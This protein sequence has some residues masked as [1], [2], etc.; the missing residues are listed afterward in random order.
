MQTTRIRPG[1]EADNSHPGR[2]TD[3][4][5]QYAAGH[6]TMAVMAGR[7]IALQV[8]RGGKGLFARISLGRH[9]PENG[10]HGGAGMLM[11]QTSL[12]LQPGSHFAPLPGQLI[13][14]CNRWRITRRLGCQAK[15]GNQNGYLLAIAL[16]IEIH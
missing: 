12:G 7:K 11:Q 9:K 5:W 13:E 1:F 4:R 15:T 2:D 3:G 16:G 14:Q 8:E 10:N 6:R